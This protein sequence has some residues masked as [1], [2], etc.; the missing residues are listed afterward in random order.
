MA[1]LQLDPKTTALI[2][3]DLQRG[4]VA[5]Q[6]APYSSTEV[7][8]KC[9]QLAKT[10]RT[11]DAPVVYVR[12]DLANMLDLPVDA[13]MPP[14]GS[15]P[16]PADFSELIPQAGFQTGDLLITKRSWGAFGG[17]DLERWLRERGTRTVVIGGIATNFGVESTARGARELGFAV[18]LAEDAM[19]SVSAEAHHFA[20][21]NI[22]PRLGRVRKTDE[23]VL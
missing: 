17:T 5:R 1:I 16:P 14:P 6:T 12:V 20:V 8:E 22:F 4:I 23:I 7:V 13:P 3:I 15:A 18:V 11:Y 9:S 10:F 21:Q 2:I 19:T